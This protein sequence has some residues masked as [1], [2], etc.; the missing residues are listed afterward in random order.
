M[1]VARGPREPPRPRPCGPG[2]GVLLAAFSPAAQARWPRLR[3]RRPPARPGGGLLA[4]SGLPPHRCAPPPPPATSP[5]ANR[6]RAPAQPP[7]PLASPRLRLPSLGRL[8]LVFPTVPVQLRACCRPAPPGARVAVGFCCRS[9]PCRPA[10]LASLAPCG[11][12]RS[13][14]CCIRRA[15]WRAGRAGRGPAPGGPRGRAWRVG[16]APALPP[17]LFR[18]AAAPP[19]GIRP[20]GAPRPHGGAGPGP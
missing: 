6:R 2:P 10:R 17:L 13:W 8:H 20:G 9:G 14:P 19:L 18:A 11:P 15:W 7:G 16:G 1:L 3:A 5:L 4:A 12:P